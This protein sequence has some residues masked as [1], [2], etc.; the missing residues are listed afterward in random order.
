LSPSG[1]KKY[2]LTPGDCFGVAALL[3][4][5][6]LLLAEARTEVE[7]LVLRRTAFDLRAG[8]SGASIQTFRNESPR[9]RPPVRVAQQEDTDCG[10]ACLAIVA[11]SHGRDVS[12]A[13]VQQRLQLGKRG[14]SLLE[15]QWAAEELGFRARAVPIG[16]E[17]L[18]SKTCR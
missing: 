16:P 18:T 1:K 3:G 10:L 5:T 11:R 12:L 14:T 6:S 13:G 15:L 8:G 17:H 7:C 4:E 9:R 2:R